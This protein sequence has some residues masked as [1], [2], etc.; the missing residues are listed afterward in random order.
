MALKPIDL[1]NKTFAK[2][3]RGYDAAE[4]QEFL[5]AAAADFEESL[6]DNKRLSERLEGLEQE[7]ARYRDMEATLNNALVLA[8]KT[9]DELRTNA[10][11][12]AELV[13]REAQAKAEKDFAEIRDKQA[14]VVSELENLQRM[15]ERFEVEFRAVLRTYLDLLGGDDSGGSSEQS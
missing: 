8:Q 14:T 11:K 5:R 9:A 3:V 7:V 12:E 13:I 1:L 4:V 2:R 6:G 10:V 15:R